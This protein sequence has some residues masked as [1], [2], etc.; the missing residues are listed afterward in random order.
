M[1]TI[2]YNKSV[3]RD[4]EVIHM[5]KVVL[6]ASRNKD[7][8]GV[9]GF[10]QR[11]RVFLTDKEPA[12]LMD[13]FH[14]FV[15]AGVEGE[16]S[17]FYVSVNA[18]DMGKVKKALVCKMVMED[19][20][21]LTK[22]EAEAASVA[23]K[24]ENAAEKHWLFDFDLDDAMQVLE[25]ADEVKKNSSCTYYKTP[26]GYAVVAEHGFDTRA[27]LEKWGEWVTLKRDD[28]LCY[29]WSKKLLKTY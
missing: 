13:R 16:F 7:N 2:G 9:A 5:T 27:L 12:E 3:E 11:Y 20:F 10:H 23:M 6:F 22:L 15:D 8:V 18:R 1:H 4:K 26:H 25:F 21:D 19:N 28:M 17:R 24:A 29:K 14:Q